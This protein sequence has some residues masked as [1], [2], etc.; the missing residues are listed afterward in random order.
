MLNSLKKVSIKNCPHHF[1]NDMINI[2]SFDP[3]ILEINKLLCK[4][5]NINIYHMKYITMKNFD[6]I[7]IDSDNLLYLIFSNVDGYIIEES[8]ADKYLIFALIDK[9]KE[10]LK[11]T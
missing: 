6:H 2:K 4:K 3:S 9:S 10:V 5:A 11:N 7:N 1:F 8:N